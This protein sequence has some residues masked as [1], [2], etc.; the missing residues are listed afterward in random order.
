MYYLNDSGEKIYTLQVIVI[1]GLNLICNSCLQSLG[2]EVNVTTQAFQVNA[3]CVVH[4]CTYNI[5]K[6][7]NLSNSNFQCPCLII[8][9]Y[10]NF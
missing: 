1:N 9:N 8:L 7:K 6:E 3:P 10:A 5:L 4:V 2:L